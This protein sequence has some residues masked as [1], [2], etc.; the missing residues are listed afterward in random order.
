MQRIQQWGARHT[1]Q[2]GFTLIELMIV[3]AIIGVLASLAMPYYQSYT[4]RAQASEGLTITAGLRADIAEQY[5]M[6]GQ[7]PTRLQLSLN[8]N[9]TLGVTGRYVESVDYQPP[10]ILVT[11]KGA[12]SA[13]GGSALGGAIMRVEPTT[14][15]AAEAGPNPS[16]GWQC[17]WDN[18]SDND[19]SLQSS[20]L[21]AGCRG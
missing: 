6:R 5:S 2:G 17:E 21:P 12:E 15:E 4:A 1:H 7:M 19:N 20:W 13:D 10:A 9:D 3:V 18:P 11:F 16:N 14:G 8:G